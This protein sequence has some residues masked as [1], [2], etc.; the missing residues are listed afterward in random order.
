[1]KSGG[2][3]TKGN[4]SSQTDDVPTK[5]QHGEFVIPRGVVDHLR[6]HLPS[7]MSHIEGLTKLHAHS[8]P[9][10]PMSGPPVSPSAIAGPPQMAQMGGMPAVGRPAAGFAQGGLVTGSQTSSQ[11]EADYQEAMRGMKG[12]STGSNIPSGHKQ[13]TPAASAPGN[14]IDKALS[15]ADKGGAPKRG[16]YFKR[17]GY[18]DGGLVEGANSFT[19]TPEGGQALKRGGFVTGRKAKP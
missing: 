12:G 5:L 6:T 16:G 1:M 17:Q 2:P 8:Q 4:P 19:P 14:S 7:V 10:A 9:P 11:D 3:V 18:A 13:A 15:D